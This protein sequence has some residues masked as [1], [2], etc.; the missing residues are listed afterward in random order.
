MIKRKW[1]PCAFDLGKQESE[2]SNALT[3]FEARYYLLAVSSHLVL[4]SDVKC[5]I[6]EFDDYTFVNTCPPSSDHRV[7][8]Y[9]GQTNCAK[10]VN[11]IA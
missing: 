5:T 6:K 8:H 11:V 4:D 7:P 9:F 3:I 1:L 2:S 10:S